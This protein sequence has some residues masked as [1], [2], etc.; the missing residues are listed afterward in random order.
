M[1][2]LSLAPSASVG[3]A[4]K[5]LAERRVLSAPVAADADVDGATPEFRAAA[6][7]AA[8]EGRPACFCDVRD[9]V[10]S[11]LEAVPESEYGPES[12]LISRL[13]KLEARG[14][15]LAASPLASLPVL[16]TDGAFV[17][18]DAA[19]AMTLASLLTDVMLVAPPTLVR[20]GSAPRARAAA[21]SVG[22]LSAS[23]DGSVSSIVSQ[24]DVARHLLTH[25]SALGPLARA[26]VASLGWAAGRV[27]TVRSDEPAARALAAMRAAGVAGV[28]VVDSAG[29]MIGSFAFPDLRAIVAD[30]LGA[31]ALPTGE[32]LA[33]SRG[34]EFWGVPAT[35]ASAAATPVEGTTPVAGAAFPPASATNRRAS[36]GERVGQD[37]VTATDDEP[38][39]AVLARLV[40]RRVHRLHVVD[41][42]SRPVGVVTLTDVLAAVVRAAAGEGGGSKA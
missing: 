23:R 11:F 29:A 21:H 33:R 19:A 32:F 14:A 8:A 28:A 6:V 15:A 18:A 10:M 35:T 7:A 1:A 41:G 20:A 5:A 4:L 13:K 38:F 9:V 25:V 16:G 3:A 42:A 36:I 40:A 34:R 24:M 30:H 31:S 12:K 22:V 17:S 37:V 39:S 2:V 27:V 26:S